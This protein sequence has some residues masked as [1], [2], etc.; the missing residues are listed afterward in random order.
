MS[1]LD[2]MA[3]RLGWVRTPEAKAAHE[4][5]SPYTWPVWAEG[6][7]QW[8]PSTMENYTAEGYQG[9][10]IIYACIARKAETAATVAL[11]V[12]SGEHNQPN[13]APD[14]HPL[15]MLV[16]RPN[17]YM[18]WFELQELLI[19][20]LELDGNCY[21]AKVRRRPGGPVEALYPLRP[22]NVR[23]VP[24]DGDLIGY[25]YNNETWLPEDIIDVKY[26]DPC[27]QYEGLGRGRSPLMAAAYVGDVDNAATKFL[28]QF[29]D[30]AVVPF[31]LLKSK[32][33]LIDA[34]IGRI[35]QRMRQQYGGV[36]NWGD[37]MILDADAEYQ[38]L[39]LSFQEMGFDDLDAR[40]EARICS[41]LKVPPILVGAKVGLDRSTFANYQEAR[42]SFWED[43]MLVMYQRFENQLN[44][45]LADTDFPG[46]WLAY[47]FSSTPALR[48][49]K[50]RQMEMAVRAFLGGVATRSEARALMGLPPVSAEDDGFRATEEQQIGAPA[51]TQTPATVDNEAEEAA[52]ATR[53]FASTGAAIRDGDDAERIAIERQA[54][55]Q[56]ASA[57]DAQWQAIQPATDEDV[58]VMEQKLTASSAA[59][60]DAIYRALRPAALLGVT[61]AQR[62]VDGALAAPPKQIG[63]DWTLVASHVIEWLATYTFGLIGG[64]NETTSAA[65]RGA[66]QRWVE[67]GLPLSDLI[68]ELV[69]VLGLFSRA[70][71]ELIASTEV[72]RAYAEAQIQAWQQTGVVQMMRWNTA[73]DERVCA[74]CAP[75]GGIEFSEDGAVPGSIEQQ[76]SDGIVTTLG[77]PFVHP[78]GSGQAER[79]QGHE[80]RSP[81]AHPR[82]R[83]WITAVF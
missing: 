61:A 34:E 35:R 4:V 10:A 45:Q 6:D 15:A 20:Y 19:T 52:K 59:L 81:P 71:A 54:A 50:T 37:I 17:R 9:N 5:E 56:I 41:V 2:V 28:K 75:L 76:L 55:R 36:R 14:A 78:G 31:G 79:W 65:L 82:C 51:I 21:L 66:I 70:R 29:F 30:N 13:M 26:P 73:N 58:Q 8:T 1:V 83:C 60:R 23:H 72:T 48:E 32:Q 7:P 27:D 18:S 3:G 39:G 16:R 47:D 62:A 64:I 74:I 42:S 63:I 67:N 43:T 25:I 44:L 40:N 46:Y 80:F 49:D 33:K 77:N 11:R 38:R 68:D 12:Y 53:P 57:L 69:V 22:D 24:K